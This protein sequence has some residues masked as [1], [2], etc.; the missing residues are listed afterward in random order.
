MAWLNRAYGKD[1]RLFSLAE[2]GLILA[3]IFLY[4]WAVPFWY[5]AIY[6]LGLPVPESLSNFLYW[7]WWEK[8]AFRVVLIVLLLL[9][10]LLG[11]Y[12]R[13]D[14]R[15][16]LGMRADNIRPSAREALAVLLLVLAGAAAIL[17]AFPNVFAVQEYLRLGP[18]VIAGDFAE[19][20]VLGL[21]Q[22]FLL[23]SIFLVR[24][25]Q[26]FARKST[27]VIASSVV[28]SLIHAPNIPLMALTLAFGLVCCVLFLR[29]RNIFVLG[30]LHGLVVQVVRFLFISVVGYG[31]SYYDLTLRVGPPSG[32]DDYLAQLQYA[33]SPVYVTLPSAFSIPVSVTNKSKAVWDSDAGRDPVFMSYHLRDDKGEM[34]D[35]E[36]A[37]TPFAGPIAP[38]ESAVVNLAIDAPPKAGNY[39]VEVDLVKLR[40]AGPGSEGERIFFAWR[41]SNSLSIPVSAN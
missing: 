23:Q 1:P 15:R 7:M 36:N 21:V 33:G 35:F 2:L 24:A 27:A 9:V 3:T 37:L 10:I 32:R 17:L 14:S 6:R 34:I 38:G 18:L 20:L 5:W 30:V 28:F 4:L 19:G 26:I 29:N 13:R 11:F 8:G 40:G 16:E 25:L 12:I 39:S 41:G 31:A 22:Q